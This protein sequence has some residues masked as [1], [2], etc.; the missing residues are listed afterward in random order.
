MVSK[1]FDVLGGAVDFAEDA[2]P[3]WMRLGFPSRAAWESAGKPSVKYD[4]WRAMPSS[5]TISG[6]AVFSSPAIA[7]AEPLPKYA[8]E[9]I[10]KATGGGG[11]FGA[12]G[13]ALDTV[14]DV[15]DKIGLTPSSVA[16][17]LLF[18]PVGAAAGALSSKTGVA[19]TTR[20]SAEFALDE[21]G[22]PLSRFMANEVRPVV[23]DVAAPIAG[24]AY[25]TLPSLVTGPIGLAAT[26][27]ASRTVGLPG[28]EQVEAGGRFAGESLTPASPV[29]IALS[30]FIPATADWADVYR[31]A[32]QGGLIDDAGRLLART[33]GEEG[34]VRLDNILKSAGKTYDELVQAAGR[35]LGPRAGIEGPLD[36]LQGQVR[37]VADEVPAPGAPELPP[38]IYHGSPEARVLNDEG[39]LFTAP[40]T[41]AAGVWGDN[42]AAYKPAPGRV[43]NIDDALEEAIMAGD[44]DLDAVVRRL[45]AD[46]KADGYSY[47]QFIH[48]GFADEDFVTTVVLNPKRDLQALDEAAGAAAPTVPTTAAPAPPPGAGGLTP[49]AQAAAP[50]TPGMAAADAPL[51]P[52]SA[53]PAPPSG[54][55]T[56][57]ATAAPPAGPG[58]EFAGN[59]RL[60][61]YPEDVQEPIRAWAEANPD[62]V[63]AARRG[64][65]PDEQVRANA[66][67]LVNDLG[68]N[69]QKIQR[70]WKPG[71]AWNAE[72]ITAIRG[73]LNDATRKVLD[74]AEA[75][76][77]VD[78]SANQV[79]LTE[80]ILEQ[81]RIQQIV[82]GVTAE[83]GRSLRAFRQNA[84]E[85][86]ADGDVARMQELLQRALGRQ[87]TPE[88]MREFTDLVRALDINNPVAVNNFLRNVNKPN[89]WDKLHFYWINSIL[90]GPITQTR[91]IVG[92]FGAA[93]YNPVQRLAA[94]GLD[95]PLARITGRP[96]ERFWQEV[97]AAYAGMIKGI[98]EGVR[99]AIETVKTGISP[100]AAAKLDLRPA[101]ISGIAGRILGAP[102]TGLGMADEFFSAITYRMSLNADAVRFA[103]KEGLTGRALTDRIAALMNDPPPGLVRQASEESE[104]LLFRG[105]PGELAGAIANVRNKMPGGRYIVPFLRTPAN[106]LKYGVKNSPLGLLD[107]PKLIK[108]AQGNPEAIDEISRAV[109]GSMIMAS[110]ASLAATGQIELTAA[111][112][113]DAAERDRFFREGKIPFGVKIPGVGWVEYK[114]IPLLDTNLTIVASAMDAID[115]GEDP[116]SAIGQTAANIG[117]NL[118]DKS[119]MSGI[120]DLFDAVQ[121]PARYAERF[122]TRHLSGYVPFSGLQRQTAQFMDSTIRAPE[123]L[124]ETVKTQIP[125]LSES[126]P[127]RLTAFGEEAERDIPSP[128][129]FSAESQTRVDAALEAAGVELGFVG[130][131]VGGR[132]LNREQQFAYQQ[133]MGRWFY[134]ELYTTVTS[135]IF[136]KLSDVQ[137]AEV[138]EERISKTRSA[139]QA[140]ITRL[141][142][143]EVFKALPAEKQDELLLLKL[144]QM[145][146]VRGRESPITGELVK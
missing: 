58:D 134:D 104:E 77:A 49:G 24:T 28:Q 6:G 39:L 105:D 25:K 130:K 109:V 92:N 139:K 73:A 88:K 108:A 146:E 79:K 114:Q 7:P 11:I 89:F 107:F 67:E 113:L 18:G 66:E 76:R 1:A 36:D 138:L 55:P 48:P 42:V 19:P 129:R 85:A 59:I 56:G 128:V 124:L 47:V 120:G 80:A 26:E 15:P 35:G 84:A 116:L 140:E 91:N 62:L 87:A 37:R 40:D 2:I 13:G 20:E 29:D 44:D 54:P 135:P 61:K 117:T 65:I 126:V 34:M 121:D 12:I 69:W 118:L 142:K 23:G 93:M 100:K 99:G 101:P 143:N 106:L 33:M 83:A 115:R 123:G 16:G 14:A 94:A 41:K 70:S 22:N 75:A 112:P 82:H 17:G 3:E 43:K 53:A 97:P 31:L 137:K 141:L 30:V 9:P 68:G 111:A 127:P 131:S 102:T 144:Q 145:G 90:S 72:E 136:A 4:E 21:Q 51:P 63:Q 60:E 10:P 122:V 132:E 32:K 119:Y 74:A 103:R 110:F 78:S 46:A 57:V 81:Q 52:A 50:G 5:S 71:E 125:G 133:A 95:A 64:T 98:P 8:K 38:V 86:L 27:L 96:Q 45:A